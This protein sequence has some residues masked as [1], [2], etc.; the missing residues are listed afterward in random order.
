MNSLRRLLRGVLSSGTNRCSSSRCRGSFEGIAT[1]TDAKNRLDAD[2]DGDE[3]SV[4]LNFYVNDVVIEWTDTANPLPIGTI[5][6]FATSEETAHTAIEV[7][8]DN[9]VVKRL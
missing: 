6:L 9:F 3:G 2:C 1:A 4:Y 5:A 7:E 8:F